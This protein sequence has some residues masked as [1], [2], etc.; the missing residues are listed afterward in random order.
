MKMLVVAALAAAV[1]VAALPPGAVQDPKPGQRPGAQEPGPKVPTPPPPTAEQLLA[2]MQAQFAK[3]GLELDAKAG[4]LSIKAFVNEARDPIE[5][6]LVHRR[7]KRHEAV[8]W[9]SAKASLL[10]GALLLLGLEQGKN[11]TY[12]EVEPLPTLEEVQAGAETVIVTPPQGKPFWITAHWTDAEGETKACCVEDLLLD[13]G[14]GK[15][16]ASTA[17]IYLGGRM[18]QIYRN[19]PEVYIADFEGNLF[20]VCY[21]S[22]DNHLATMVH[23]R[24]RDDQNWLVTELLPPVDT[25]VKLVV[26]KQK[27]KLAVE[28]EARL[29]KANADAAAKGEGKAPGAGD[30]PPGGS[31][32][33]GGGAGRGG[34]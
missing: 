13:L 31:G 3:E 8:F 33:S 30:P 1:S 27:P 2:E 4:T 15:A 26:H 6:L 22:P 29:A 7:G 34:D 24:S 11:A 12:K 18:A 23:E 9:T 21:L 28:R 20:S 19:E 25:E 10:N 5:Y 14:A 17:W 16:V 32:N